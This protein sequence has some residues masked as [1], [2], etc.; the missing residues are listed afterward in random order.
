VRITTGGILTVKGKVST[1]PGSGGGEAT[2]IGNPSNVRRE[3]AIEVG[4]GTVT[5]VVPG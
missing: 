4:R 3:A 5:F 1:K 2:I